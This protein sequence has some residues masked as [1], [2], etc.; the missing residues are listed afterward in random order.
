MTFFG[1]AQANGL[2]SNSKLR[3]GLRMLST[4]CRVLLI[5]VVSIMLCIISYLRLNWKAEQQQQQRESNLGLAGKRG[6]ASFCGS[7]SHCECFRLLVSVSVWAQLVD[8]SLHASLRICL[9]N[10][11]GRYTGHSQS[12]ER[13][14][15]L[16]S[17]INYDH[18]EEQLPLRQTHTLHTRTH[19]LAYYLKLKQ[20]RQPVIFPFR[21]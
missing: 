13:G 20:I 16:R 7:L 15:V 5:V 2:A 12:R 11:L 8:G 9:I 17:G 18:V 3:S 4:F 21:L 14:R 1:W 19:P 6:S 10:F